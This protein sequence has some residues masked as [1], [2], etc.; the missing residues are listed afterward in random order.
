[1]KNIIL[2]ILT[3]IL[4]GCQNTPKINMDS[5]NKIPE[6]NSFVTDT[7]RTKEN[8]KF[9]T[10]SVG[11]AKLFKSTTRNGILFDISW[12]KNKQIDYIYTRDSKFK[13][14]EGVH[15]N[16]TLKELKTIQNKEIIMNEDSNFYMKLDSGWYAGFASNKSDG[17]NEM[18][19]V[20][21]L[22]KK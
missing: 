6:L 7:N 21:V 5:I 3:L 20:R 19:K 17:L 16:M 2:S 1:M 10:I 11:S 8:S 22:L 18:D 12:K 13:T 15:V 9:I 14:E 4:F